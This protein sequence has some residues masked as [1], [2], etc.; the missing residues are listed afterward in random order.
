MHRLPA[1]ARDA[2]ATGFF[3]APMI[4]RP[5][6]ILAYLGRSDASES[7]LALVNML[8]P[9]VEQSLKA[10]LGYSVEYAEHTLYLPHE[11]HT[12]TG[13]DVFA[14]IL[15]GRVYYTPV[16]DCRRE[17]YLP[18]LP[19]RG[20]SELRIDLAGNFGQTPGSF[21]GGSLTEGVQFYREIDESGLCR[22]GKL[23]CPMGWPTAPGSVQ[24]TFAAGYTR[25]ELDGHSSVPA[26][27]Q[28]ATIK[29][30]A[31]LAVSHYFRQQAAQDNNG[32]MVV[33]E[34]LAGWS[35]TLNT[36]LTTPDFDLPMQSKR[37]LAPFWR[38]R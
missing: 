13:D 12:Q 8:Q 38:P 34:S 27:A 5:A 21:S 37:I 35:Q 6:E 15:D 30:A 1:M 3:H 9:L 32:G 29:F 22:S 7:D 20:V 33:S 2:G 19:V 4:A 14:G 36:Q 31:I 16:G 24:V 10:W 17:L 25:E 23:I 28:A 26:A 11:A 18:E